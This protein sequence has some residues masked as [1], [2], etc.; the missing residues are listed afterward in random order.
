MIPPSVVIP[1]GTDMLRPT[2]TWPGAGPSD[3]PYLDLSSRTSGQQKPSMG[4][5]LLGLL[6]RALA[7][8]SGPGAPGSTGLS[9]GAVRGWWPGTR[10]RLRLGLPEEQEKYNIVTKDS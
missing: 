1:S 7:P 8:G 6:E 5:G 2:G 10:G 3:R 9:R 4:G